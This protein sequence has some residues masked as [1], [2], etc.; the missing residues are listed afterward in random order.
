MADE[1]LTPKDVERNLVV[2]PTTGATVDID[3]LYGGATSITTEIHRVI[4][5]S[6]EHDVWLVEA[7]LGKQRRDFMDQETLAKIL[8]RRFASG[9]VLVK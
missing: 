9:W 2:P 7:P 1:K 5:Y 6:K 8:I 4:G 3:S